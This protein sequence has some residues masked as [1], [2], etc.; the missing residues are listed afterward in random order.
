VHRR[1]FLGTVAGSLLAAPL[2]AGAQPAGKVWRIGFAAPMSQ[3]SGLYL[4][5]GFRGGLRDL[6]YVESE[7]IRIEDRWAD[8]NLDRFPELLAGLVALRVDVIVV[9]SVYGARAAKSEATSMPVVFTLV[10]DPIG[11]GLV[12]NL[13]K[14][15]GH[16]TGIAAGLGAEISAKWVDLVREALPTVSRLGILANPANPIYG[17][18]LAAMSVAAQARGLT[19]RVFEARDANELTRAFATISKEHLGA[20]II[21]ADVLFRNQRDR[22]VDFA[23]GQRIPTVFYAREF[24]EAGGLMTYGPNGPDMFRQAASYVDRILKGAKPGDL[25]IEQPA[26]FEFVINL[27]TAKALGLTIPPSLLARADEVIE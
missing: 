25:P 5:E 8:G 10:P 21:A 20:L 16:L 4:L 19:L 11:A 14:P 24:A 1:T 13:A 17:T 22:I 18:S 12:T 27:K 15:G 6:G 26:K 9:A 2:T 3:A 7:S 23:A